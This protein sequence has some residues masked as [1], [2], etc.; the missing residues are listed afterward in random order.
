MEEFEYFEDEF[1]EFLK[2]RN[3]NERNIFGRLQ[4]VGSFFNNYG[5]L[6]E[7]TY[8]EYYEYLNDNCKPSTVNS[9]IIA[10]NLYVKFLEQKYNITLEKMC[11]K[12][13]KIKKVQF[14]EDI[15]TIDEYLFFM[16]KA[17]ARNKDKLY[18]VCK[19]M[20]T[21]GMRI[22]ETL[23]IRREH[24]EL[25][26]IDFIGKGGKERRCYFTPTTQKEV[27][28]LLDKHC[29]TDKQS[30]VVS[31][32]WNGKQL[33]W[34]DANVINKSMRKF[35]EDECELPKGLFHPH[36]FRHFFAKNFIKKYQNIALLADLLGHSNLDTTRIYLK[37]TS[38][39]QREVV[40]EVVTW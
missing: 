35:A 20:A 13:I 27:L 10:L 29:V 9:S 4:R 5:S 23:Q 22:H 24:I 17:K 18:V 8:N 38:R 14:L 36:M 25:G 16:N 19:I 32:N 3:C 15:A 7:E 1:T 26:F 28:A 30:Y 6:N 34:K 33:S 31:S 2:N 21:T 37:Y 40:N 11:A 39:E 12:T